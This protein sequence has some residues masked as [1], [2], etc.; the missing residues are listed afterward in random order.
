[1]NVRNP[2]MENLQRK[3]AKK[4]DEALPDGWG[5]TL[6]LYEYSDEPGGACFYISS[7]QRADMVKVIKEWLALQVQ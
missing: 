3:L 1:M 7:S 4:I 2:D 6:F 5:F